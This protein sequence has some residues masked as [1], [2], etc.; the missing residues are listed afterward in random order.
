MARS[1]K[2]KVTLLIVLGCVLAIVAGQR[3]L[4]RYRSNIKQ[5]SIQAKAKGNPQA[6]LKIIEYIDL[7]CPACAQ[8]AGILNEYFKKY[9]NQMYV[10]LKYFPLSGHRWS[11]PSA[12]YAECAARQNKFWPFLDVLLKQQSF[13]SALND[14]NPAFRQ[15]AQEAGLNTFQ[16]D[17][18]LGD[19]YLEEAITTDKSIGTA[20]GIQ[21]TPTYFI[22][23]K[24][25]VGTKFLKEQLAA[26]FG[27][28][29]NPQP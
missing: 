11:M 9:P 25:F 18:C 3:I 24:M 5:N 13:W 19:K 6:K 21:S 10:E 17:L 27:E 2:Q 29:A 15:I 4:H 23:D 22:N 26:F 14:P 20:M 28:T 16:L 7:E 8:G 1:S 12:R